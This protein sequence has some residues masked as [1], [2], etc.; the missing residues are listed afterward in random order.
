MNLR[1]IGCDGVDCIKMAQEMV[2]FEMSVKSATDSLDS[3]IQ[4]LL[5]S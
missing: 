1:E 4:E 3:L 2:Q 5:N